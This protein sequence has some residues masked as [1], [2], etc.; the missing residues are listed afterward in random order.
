MFGPRQVVVIFFK[1]PAVGQVVGWALS[2]CCAFELRKKSTE[3]ELPYYIFFYTSAETI[4]SR[5]PT[6]DSFSFQAGSELNPMEMDKAL[7]DDPSGVRRALDFL[8]RLTL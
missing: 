8:P 2:C 3:R 5:R 4:F 1:G 6:P 7:G